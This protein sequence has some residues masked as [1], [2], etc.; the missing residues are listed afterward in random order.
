[1]S[2]P[3]AYEKK[4]AY[5]GKKNGEKGEMGPTKTKKRPTI[6]KMKVIKLQ[7]NV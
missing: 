2:V 7:K 6:H 3:R 4:G 5:K 1:M